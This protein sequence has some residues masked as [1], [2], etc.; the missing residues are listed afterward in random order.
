VVPR[1]VLG[2]TAVPYGR[3]EEYA[4]IFS[5]FTTVQVPL[6][7]LLGDAAVLGEAALSVDVSEAVDHCG[8]QSGWLVKSP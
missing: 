4:Y 2:T 7:L 6:H 1:A 5:T 8:V 3:L